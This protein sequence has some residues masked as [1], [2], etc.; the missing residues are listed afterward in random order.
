MNRAYV[1]HHKSPLCLGEGIHHGLYSEGYLCGLILHRTRSV[2]DPNNINYWIEQWCLFYE[3]IYKKFQFFKNCH[4]VIYEKL[5]NPSYVEKILN[6]INLEKNKNIDLQFF[7]NS[8]KKDINIEYDKNIFYKS[9]LLY[10][11][12]LKFN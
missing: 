2:N 6:K 3:L 12:F 1:D 10:Q 4:F 7:S 9:Q 11:K 8:N 5:H